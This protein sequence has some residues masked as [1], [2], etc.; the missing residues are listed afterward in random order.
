LKIN[1]Q[2][3]RAKKNLKLAENEFRGFDALVK[4]ITKG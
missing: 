2:F 4:V 3:E 1:P